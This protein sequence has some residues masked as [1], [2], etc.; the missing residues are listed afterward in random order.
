MQRWRHMDLLQSSGFI[1]YPSLTG[2]FLRFM[3]STNNILRP[4]QST[5][6]RNLCQADLWS[7]MWEQMS[8]FFRS[9]SQSG[10]AK[11]AKSYRSNQRIETTIAYFLRLS[12][13]ISSTVFIA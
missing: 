3:P 8:A 11:V 1:D 5:D 4:V 7:S 6:F 9:A 13:R 10:S 12:G 2:F